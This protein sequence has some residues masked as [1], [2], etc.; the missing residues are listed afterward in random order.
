VIVQE[1]SDKA[2]RERAVTISRVFAKGE[3]PQF[4]QARVRGTPVL[5]Q[6]D[7]KNRWED[8]SLRHAL[9]SFQL[10]LPKGQAI[11]VDFINQPS[12]NN[13]SFLKREDILSR[14]FDGVMEV[15]NGNTHSISIRKLL[16]DW[17]GKESEQGIRYWMKG[18][19]CT[20]IIV[21][22]RSPA[23]ANDF[24]WNLE[25][26]VS[27]ANGAP[28][29]LHP[30]FV[31]TFCAGWPGVRIEFILENTFTETLQDQ[32]Y[33]VRLFAGAASKPVFQQDRFRHIAKT[34][35]RKIFWSG[36]EPGA[37][38]VNY[39]LPYLIHS[40]V[41]P[42]FDLR[43]SVPSSAISEE[44]NAFNKKYSEDLG[45][46]GVTMPAFPTTGGNGRGDVGL[47]PR[48]DVRYLYTFSPALYRVILGQAEVGA[49]VPVHLRESLTDRQFDTTTRVNAFGRNLSVDARP[50]VRT[51]RKD[52]GTR[53]RD[54]I[55]PV[56]P[57]T[58]G[59][60][61]LDQAHQPSFA[62]IPYIIT[63]DWYFLE[64]L[65]MWSGFNLAWTTVGDCA[66]CRGKFTYLHDEVRG[67]AW[68]LRT[69][70]HTAFAA[71]DG[72]P[73]KAYFT[74]KLLNNIAVR[75]GR[76]NIKD[77]SFYDPSPGSPWRWGRE[78]VGR[79]QENPLLF[80]SDGVNYDNKAPDLVRGKVATYDRA[81][82]YAYN[83][84]VW[85]HIEELG[86]PIGPLR[87][88]MALNLL[89]QLVDP[90]YN[91]Y[92]T[93]NYSMPVKS[94]KDW[95]GSRCESASYYTS[96]GEVRQ[97]YVE[98]DLKTWRKDGDVSHPEGGYALITR[99][100]ASFL[101]GIKDGD[102]DGM[103]AWEWI[104]AHLPSKD[105]LKANP[106]W[107]FV[108]RG[109]QDESAA[110]ARIVQSLGAGGPIQSASLPGDVTPGTGGD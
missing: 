15:A 44:V 48:W 88:T 17:D 95:N 109:S 82:M 84:V 80:Q 7:V 13:E 33:S 71:P 64:E 37:V 19:V 36:S 23:R 69:L 63:G 5:T 103:A 42:A 52:R 76:F 56:G 51:R 85:A 91:P 93:G 101:P 32:L 78:T 68:A 47:F 21:E 66:Y 77:G 74:R 45:S 22:D 12:G 28:K 31:A 59:G 90:A 43:L 57:V 70:A 3:I 67:E 97:G 30:A 55:D 102:L 98:P 60:W 81:W 20:Q 73:E 35:W 104:D 54:A 99:A 39:N 62:F 94:C 24:G 9:I 16:E 96:W 106:K 34:R 58:T 38:N 8:G 41:I 92:L 75:E 6:C 86:F 89:H 83:H 72:T 87:R 108:P 50:T 100:A 110:W 49:H 26:S 105:R 65:Y 27:S 25:Q 14:Q 46:K 4:A 79:G 11:E 10:D 1:L 40:K 29:S 53:P 107:A 2:Q 18:P 61:V